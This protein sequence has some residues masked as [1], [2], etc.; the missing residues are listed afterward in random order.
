M[1]TRIKV[2]PLKYNG[3]KKEELVL[4]KIELL[5]SKTQKGFYLIINEKLPSKK[6]EK[7]LHNTF[8]VKIEPGNQNIEVFSN[9]IAQKIRF[10]DSEKVN[11]IF[12]FVDDNGYLEMNNGKFFTDDFKIE[13]AEYMVK[14]NTEGNVRLLDCQDKG[15]GK[16]K[17]SG[18][19]KKKPSDQSSVKSKTKKK[20]KGMHPVNYGLSD[21]IK[22]QENI[23]LEGD[24]K[25]PWQFKAKGKEFTGCE[26]EKAYHST[27][28]DA[29]V[30]ATDVH[31]GTKIAKKIGICMEDTSSN[32]NIKCFDKKKKVSSDE[33]KDCY[34]IDDEDLNIGTST[35]TIYDV[36]KKTDKFEQWYNYDKPTVELSNPHS[37][38]IA[39]EKNGLHIYSTIGDGNC[40]FH[41]MA[42]SF[43]LQVSDGMNTLK[44]II[45]DYKSQNSISDQI[46]APNIGKQ[47]RKIY[48]YHLKHKSKLEEHIFKIHNSCQ[49]GGAYAQAYQSTLSQIQNKDIDSW[50]QREITSQVHESA[51][52][53]L[54]KDES[55]DYD[56]DTK[57]SYLQKIAYTLM[58]TQ[59]IDLLSDNEKVYL[60][61]LKDDYLKVLENPSHYADADMAVELGKILGIKVSVLQ[62]QKHVHNSKNFQTKSKNPF[63]I[64]KKQDEEKNSRIKHG[65]PKIVEHESQIHASQAKYNIS[66]YHTGINHFEALGPK[67]GTQAL[68]S[69][70]KKFRVKNSKKANKKNRKVRKTKGKSVKKKKLI[71][72]KNSVKKQK[73]NRKKRT[74][75]KQTNKSKKNK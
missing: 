40:L 16:Q 75:F 27:K 56:M 28:L 22:G 64:L 42:G 13:M 15:A 9:K 1:T 5:N 59:N 55:G 23:Y 71:K 8:S 60:S 67:S 68:A 7:L 10:L 57:K 21:K 19:L 3:D 29:K 73:L 49:L 54:N 12:Y 35:Y 61:L 14:L 44:K 48:I 45:Q 30:C 66:I 53:D 50:S 69:G 39:Q 26:D 43:H 34:E 58:N 62:V 6:Y 25:F 17:K 74:E 2:V 47:L 65:Q 20:F 4:E 41:S 31:K 32:K 70:I 72:K 46:D 36:E 38:F 33:V 52:I 18:S 51:R 11:H 24:C 63:I 37:T